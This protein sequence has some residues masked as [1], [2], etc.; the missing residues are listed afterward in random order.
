MFAVW[1]H[2][3]DDNVDYVD[4]DNN[5]GDAASF[6]GAGEGTLRKFIM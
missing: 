2:Q 4:D 3:A 1:L 6:D 5:P